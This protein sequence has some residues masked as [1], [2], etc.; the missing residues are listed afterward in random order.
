[1]FELSVACKY[2][3]PRWRQLSVSI[4]SLISMLVISLVV[5]LIVVFFSVKDGLE[6]SWIE[7]LIALTAPVRIIPTEKYYNSYYYLIDTISSASDY[8]QKTIGEKLR[9]PVADPY[10]P[11]ID[12]EPPAYWQPPD[13]RFDG[14]LKDPVKAAFRAVTALSDVPGLSARDFEMTAG[15]LHLRLLRDSPVEEIPSHAQISQSL[16]RLILEQSAYIGAYDP[17]APAMSK[18]MMPLMPEDIRN[19]LKLIS[20]SADNIQEDSTD[21]I[22]WLDPKIIQ[23]RVK[24]F[25]EAVTISELRTPSQGWRL[26]SMLFPQ[27]AVFK[28]C[29]IIKGGNLIRLVIP[30][31]AH[32]VSRFLKTLRSKGYAAEKAVVKIDDKQ[33]A[34]K[35]SNSEFQQLSPMVPLVI[36]NGVSFPG[37]LVEASLNGARQPQ[38]LRFDVRLDI[39]GVLLQGEIPMSDLEIGKVQ[40]HASKD[41]KNPFSWLATLSASES[42]SH[43]PL[44]SDPY[45]GEGIFLPK[46][47]KDGGTLIGDQGYLSYYSPTASTIQE[48]RIPIFVAG[49]YDPGIIPLGGKYILASQEIATLIRASYNQDDTFLNNGI[50]V[51][52]DNLEQADKVKKALV[53]QFKREGIDA[54]WRVETYQEYEFTKD[55][56]Q[57]LR[58]EKNLFTLIS[59]V[60][61]IVACS[62]IIS[63]LIILVNDKK[64]EIGIL[65]SM[66]A[67]SW[68]IAAIFGICGMVM[69]AIG[70]LVGILAALLTLWNLE[71]LVS[72]ISR[73]Q[74]YEMFNPVFYGDTLPNEISVQALG[75][76][77]LA[78]ALISLLA[79]LVP[80]VKAS[81]LRPSAIL[82][83]E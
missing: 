16:I 62:N 23:Q 79:G 30:K 31:S 81:L 13:R 60:I 77:V 4:I 43:S 25:F 19:V 20:I 58:S 52:F 67:S 38:D 22:H 49:F 73:Y 15:N 18:A 59:T 56:I 76:V 61:I 35:V 34:V 8:T 39:Q 83:S 46:S 51:H 9:S 69:G 7:K 37:T 57:Q 68:S 1:M 28:A 26:P 70:S 74:G 53:D 14:S 44:P 12:E 32:D 5:W 2:L 66:G 33:V 29:A 54:Y 50:N 71:T 24:Q 10:D 72:L 64:V 27:K 40:I 3:V 75:F 63:M 21:D 82:R 41:K 55:L 47:F 36:A 80:A 65:R 11:N 45:N 42:S 78:T 6:N 17:E 48:Q